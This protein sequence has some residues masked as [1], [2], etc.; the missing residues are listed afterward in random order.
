M[1]VYP[2]KFAPIRGDYTPQF[3]QLVRDLLQKDPEFRPTA[4]EVLLSKLPEL[5]A[6][7]DQRLVMKLPFN[8]N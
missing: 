4:S 8:R 7:H 2:I 5:Q 6:L 3:K 1:Q